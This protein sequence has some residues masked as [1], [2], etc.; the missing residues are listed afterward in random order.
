MIDCGQLTADLR[1]LVRR[2]ETDIREYSEATPAV[3]DRLRSEH[4]RARDAKRTGQ[5]FEGW[6]DEQV[7][8]SAVAWVLACVFVR[9]CE[10]NALI[11]QPRLSGPGDR[12]TAAAD[13]TRHHFQGNPGDSDREYLLW[14]FGE[15]AR[16]PGMGDLLDERHSGLSELP[17]SV[18]GAAELLAFW[19]QTDPHSG[20]LV[21]DF[22][23]P[24]RDTRFLGDL[25]QDLSEAARKRYALLQTP[26][27]VEEFILDRTLEP[28]IADFGLADT[29]LIDPACGSGHF[30]LGAFDRLLARWREREP[31][32]N[33]RQLCQEVLD[34]IAGVDVNPYATAIARFRLLVAAL[35]ACEIGSLR[36]APNFKISVAT[37]DSLLHG[38]RPGQ[39]PEA[40][41]EWA[42]PEHQHFYEIEDGTELRRILDRR[43]T[44]VVANPPYITPK[45]PALREAYR[46]RYATCHGKYAL[47]VPFMERLFDLAE[48]SNDSRPTGYVGQIT[49]NSFMKREFG[50][51]LVENYLADRDLT[52]I[53]DTSGAY[54]P[55]HGTPTVILAG[56][57]RSP[58]GE[59]VRGVLGIRGEPS[60]PEDPATGKVWSEI[61]GFVDR[62]GQEGE[63]VSVEDVE[64]PRLAAHPWSLQ[65]GGAA[66]VRLAVERSRA[67]RLVDLAQAVGIASVTG[68]DDLYLLGDEQT[69]RRLGVELTRPLVEGDTLRDWGGETPN[70]ALWTYSDDFSVRPLGSLGRAALLLW[71]GRAAISRRRRFGTPMLDRG[72]SW[73]E[74]QELYA[75]KLRI[76]LSI[77]F[78]FVA[79][80]N[81]FVLDRGGKVFKQSAPVIKLPEGSSE[82]D[83]LAL[84][85]PLNSS[86]GCFWMK[87]VFHNKGAGGGTRVQSGRSPLGDESWESHFEHDSTKLKQFPLPTEPP[88]VLAGAIDAAAQELSATR[89]KS[90]LERQTPSRERFDSARAEWRR[91]RDR[92]IALQEELDWRCYHLY[93]LT[94]E[95]LTVP[96]DRVPEVARGERAFEIDLS[97]RMAAGAAETRWFERHGSTPI[98][99]LPDRWPEDY[100]SLV[101]RRLQAIEASKAI[102][103]IERPEYKRR[104]QTD[105]WE[106]MEHA[107]VRSWLLDRLES[108]AAWPE[109]Q[110]VNAAR[111][112][113]R[114]LGDAD[115]TTACGLFVGEDTEPGRVVAS[116]VEEESAPYLA[117]LRYTASGMAKR[118]VWER[119]WDL[120]RAEDALDALTELPEDDPRHLTPERAAQRKRSEVGPIDVPPKYKQGDFRAGSYWRQ[121]GKLDVPKER[122]VSY[123]DAAAD[124]STLYGWAGWD[125][126]DRAQALAGRIVDAQEADGLPAERLMPLLAGLAE[127]L[128]WLRQWHGDTDPRFGMPLSDFYD[129]LLDERTQAIGATRADLAAWRPPEPVRG[130]RRRAAA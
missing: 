74:W 73:W 122:F 123:P 59:T 108:E 62:P 27:F 69:S 118:A 79:T 7:T 1:R 47:P 98:T 5:A 94:D 20:N 103:L 72:L 113:D 116:L 2:L 71:T 112:A 26:V 24:A 90:I 37:G 35:N 60:T 36:G 121:R 124:G 129:T 28:A 115:F 51:K 64:R 16:L 19:R 65:G 120:Q 31:E 34:R 49:A 6:R 17:L 95:D 8:L 101:E 117:A 97:R 92:M 45:D 91:L 57:P 54:I 109:V 111:I 87:Q 58:V 99:E 46:E 41:G 9:F 13:T 15:S 76:P 67:A 130:R 48:Q 100:R 44:A 89:P 40:H 10:D 82:Q 105:G 42:R 80:H 119:T 83:H 55:G 96:L 70:P 88:L 23:D 68:E 127:L 32:T 39:L 53:I 126:A 78:A 12:L 38:H 56:R 4:Q 106:A 84:L 25:Y 81:H 85:G 22:S 61:V 107:A 86:A 75:D 3:G 125:H 18:D 128:P 102:R 52:H 66:D 21:H 110:L 104:W 93:G 114:L 30:L 43:Y 11:A 33:V 50:K 29:T 63:Y 77:A 14:A